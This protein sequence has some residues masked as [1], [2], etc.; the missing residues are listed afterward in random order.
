[1]RTLSGPASAEIEVKR[2]R[3]IAHATRVDR[4]A[5]TLAF[6]NQVSD[7]AATHN[8]WAWKLDH[9]YRFS[10][11][12]EP[13]GTAGKPILS[14]IEGKGLDHVMVVV[15]RHFGGTKLGVGGLIRAYSAAAARCIDEAMQVDVVAECE[16]SIEAGF[17]WTGGVYAALEACQAEKLEETYADGG[18]R[19][20][21]RV[22]ETR[23]Q[24]LC[25]VLRDATRGEARVRR[26]RSS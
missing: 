17:G 6:H 19:I 1:M 16:C 18:I 5:E 12:G 10:D 3:F 21:A 13:G 20:Q 23:F 26:R 25:T 4:L 11:D 2:S 9:Q 15:T 24:E 14:A 8:C 7:P 22:A